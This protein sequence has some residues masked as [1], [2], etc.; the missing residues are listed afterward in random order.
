MANGY[1][2][3]D[4][5]GNVSEWCNDWWS[6]SYYSSSPYA[7]PTGPATSSYRVNRG[8]GWIYGALSLRSAGRYYYG[9]TYRNYGI[10]FRVLAVRP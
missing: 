6:L 10:G 1:G 9:P 5:A 2:L 4:M 7:N 3:Y 8:G